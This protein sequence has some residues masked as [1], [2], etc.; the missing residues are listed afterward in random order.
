MSIPCQQ[1]DK[2]P[3]YR[4]TNE[5]YNG[6]DNRGRT[7]MCPLTFLLFRRQ[8]V[9]VGINWCSTVDSNDNPI[10]RRDMLCPVELVEHIGDTEEIRTLMLRICSP[11]P[12]FF[13]PQ[14]HELV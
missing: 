8:R 5:P 12:N 11:K 10:F 4:Y 2:L 1:R 6:A 7:C 13:E 14:C 9:Y 3:Y